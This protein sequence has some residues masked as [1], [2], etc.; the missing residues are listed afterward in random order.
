[1]AP[2]HTT[3]VFLETRGPDSL[4]HPVGP[5]RGVY[6]TERKIPRCD[7]AATTPAVKSMFTTRAQNSGLKS[8]GQALRLSSGG[9]WNVTAFGK[10]WKIQ[11]KSKV[12]K[13]DNFVCLE[14]EDRF[15]DTQNR[16]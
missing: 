11:A 2:R 8:P 14:H 15:A 6:G 10:E 1:M 9:T 12:G 5:R 16:L 4:L 7:A 3:A 13:D